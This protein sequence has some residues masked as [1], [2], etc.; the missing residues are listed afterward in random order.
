MPHEIA[1]VTGHHSLKG[2]QRY[3][4]SVDQMKLAQSAFL[5]LDEA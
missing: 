2:I 4:K 5:K 3:T 1:A